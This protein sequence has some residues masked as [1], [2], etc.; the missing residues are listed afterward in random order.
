MG[1]IAIRKIVGSAAALLALQGASAQPFADLIN[2]SYQSLSTTYKDSAAAP[3]RSD[4]FYANLMV[5]VK[6]DS[7]NTIIC[8]FYGEKLVTYYRDR[9]VANM[10]TGAESAVNS[11][12]LPLGVQHETKSKKW[13]FLGLVMPK[14]SSDFAEPLSHYDFQLGGYAMATYARSENLKIKFGLFYNREAFGNFFVPI[15]AVDWRPCSWFQMYGVLPNNYRFEFAPWRRRLHCGI[16]FKSYTRSYRLSGK[17]GRDYVRNDEIQLKAFADLYVAKRYVLFGEFGRTFGY[18]PLVYKYNTKEFSK[19][20]P[21]YLPINDAFF[22]N[23]GLAYRIR[24]DFE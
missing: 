14:L 11:A 17:Y 3:N 22:F 19:S 23:V 8:R 6:L 5:P 15:A 13:K 2:V 12:L 7:Q 18:S 16:G 20:A 24:F 1:L 10:E 21:Q 9:S 4:N